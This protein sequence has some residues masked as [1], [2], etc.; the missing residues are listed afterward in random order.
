MDG[1]IIAAPHV[2]GAAALLIGRHREL[3]RSTPLG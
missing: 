1:T 3:T 2:S